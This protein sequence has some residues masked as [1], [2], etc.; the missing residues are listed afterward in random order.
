[1]CEYNFRYDVAIY[2]CVKIKRNGQIFLFNSEKLR[3]WLLSEE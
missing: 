1:M 3:E 2:L